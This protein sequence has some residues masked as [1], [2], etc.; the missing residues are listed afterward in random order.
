MPD[1]IAQRFNMVESQ[2]RTSDVPN[3]RIQAAMLE[4][5]RERFVPMLQRALA[6]AEKAVQ[7]VHG[8]Y[9]IEPRTLAKLLL[10]A[11]PKAGES[12]LVVG[13]GTGYSAAIMG[14]L[15]ASVTALESDVDL[16]RAASESLPALG[17]NNVR[18]VQG[19]LQDGFKPSAPYDIIL[20]DAGVEEVPGTL[21]DQLADR[22]RLVAVVMR[23]SSFGQAHIYVRRGHNIGERQDFDASAPILPGFRKAK[24]FVF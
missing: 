17:A 19:A 24:A 14:K 2:V 15:V 5:P 20:I 18:V 1:Y 10:L 13:A 3:G 11:D 8:R 23:G 9:L 6:Y 22:G 4:V 12:A 7:I 21:L 16:V